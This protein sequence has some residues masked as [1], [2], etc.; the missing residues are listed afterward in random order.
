MILIHF[1]EV[2]KGFL[3]NLPGFEKLRCFKGR[4]IPF[5]EISQKLRDVVK[6]NIDEIGK[7]ML[8][9][10]RFKIFFSKFD[11]NMRRDIEDILIGE[12]EEELYN[13]SKEWNNHNKE[14]FFVEIQSDYDL[15]PGE[16]YI[17]CSMDRSV[18]KIR[19]NEF[20]EN[21]G[22][23][24]QTLI[25]YD[26]DLEDGFNPL[27]GVERKFLPLISDDAIKI[28]KETSF[29][30]DR[31][32]IYILK[33]SYNDEERYIDLERGVYTVGRSERCDIYLKSPD[34]IIS[35]RHIELIMED[36]KIFVNPLG[37][38]GTYLNGVNLELGKR[39]EIFI[40]DRIK[41]GDFIFELKLWV[42]N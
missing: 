22:S 30:K 38:N 26:F 8:I 6:E 25:E 41:I 17:E 37:I 15:K 33:I 24:K 12:L 39:R 20:S 18:S 4:K 1:F 19:E 36:N 31:N 21:V 42:F 27:L 14:Y 32:R 29:R 7:K 5:S 34:H 9:P 40:K 3:L 11:R 13:I 35:R 23:L 2:F 16:F 10:N 28:I